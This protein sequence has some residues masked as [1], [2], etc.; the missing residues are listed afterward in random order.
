MRAAS[1]ALRL[2]PLGANSPVLSALSAVPA[3]NTGGFAAYTKVSIN[4]ERR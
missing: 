3:L 1:T 4:N 2:P